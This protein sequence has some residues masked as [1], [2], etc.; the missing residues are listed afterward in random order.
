M[1]TKKPM[2]KAL[3]K[4]KADKIEALTRGEDIDEPSPLEPPSLVGRP[5][6]YQDKFAEQAAKLCALGATDEDLA[7][8]FNVNIRTVKRWMVEFPEF[9][10]AV[11]TAKEEANDR[12]ERSLYQRAVGYTFDAVKIMTSAGKEMIVP[13]REHVPPDVTAQIFWLKNR[14]K[15]QWRDKTEQDINHKMTLSGE[16]ESFMRQ[17]LSKKEPQQIEAVEIP[18][19]EYREVATEY[20]ASGGE[21]SKSIP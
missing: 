5:R 13:Y 20:S 1:K 3:A 21:T 15:D 18:S 9:C 10:H 14:R 11:K 6:T 7:D 17:V 2:S 12:V 4:E 19:S 8:F 16:F